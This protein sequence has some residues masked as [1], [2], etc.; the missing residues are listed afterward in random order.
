MGGIGD[1]PISDLVLLAFIVI[2]G[3]MVV[4]AMLGLAALAVFRPD[5]D[6]SGAINQFGHV[7]SVMIGAI[8]GYVAGRRAAA[9]PLPKGDP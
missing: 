8:L 5:L 6:L 1:K 2:L 9:L 4:A 7:M 3:L